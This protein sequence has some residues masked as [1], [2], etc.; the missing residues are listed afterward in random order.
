MIDRLSLVQSPCT[1]SGQETERVH[2]YNPGARMGH[3]INCNTSVQTL[4]ELLVV[5]LNRRVLRRNPPPTML[6]A[7]GAV[8]WLVDKS[9]PMFVFPDWLNTGFA[10]TADWCLLTY[11][12]ITVII[13]C[14]LW[15]CKWRA[16][17]KNRICS[18][19]MT[20]KITRKASDAAEYIDL[21]GSSALDR[22]AGLI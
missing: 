17:W 20:G 9:L 14:I 11:K 1:T 16:P 3:L 21:F 8:G 4:T 7:S 5:W 13:T 6:L 2:S 19:T 12:C 15:R 22:H 18:T 10:L